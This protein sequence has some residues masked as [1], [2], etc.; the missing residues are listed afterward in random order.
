M[1]RLALLAVIAMFVLI[2]EVVGVVR[3]VTCGL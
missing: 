2:G 3:R 1:K